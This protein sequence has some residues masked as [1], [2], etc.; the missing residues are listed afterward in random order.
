MDSLSRLLLISFVLLIV[1][2]DLSPG[3]GRARKHYRNTLMRMHHHSWSVSELIEGLLNLLQNWLVPDN[4][5]SKAESRKFFF[6]FDNQ[7]NGSSNFVGLN[8]SQ[9]NVAYVS[10]PLYQPLFKTNVTTVVY[11]SECSTLSTL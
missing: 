4:S 8:V 9:R 7:N 11:F 1:S 3:H 6:L 5:A 2:I 10:V